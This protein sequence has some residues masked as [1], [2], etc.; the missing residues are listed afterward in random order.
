MRVAPWDADSF[1]AKL[2]AAQEVKHRLDTTAQ[3]REFLL[4]HDDVN[5][6]AIGPRW[7]GHTQLP[8]A[9]AMF[10]YEQPPKVAGY[11]YG[12]KK[13]DKKQSHIVTYT[14]ETNLGK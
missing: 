12:D 14:G 1:E 3:N 6:K 10:V 13:K 7:N 9:K 5:M 11:N 2:Y 4:T 8:L